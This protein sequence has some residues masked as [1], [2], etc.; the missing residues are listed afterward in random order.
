MQ[1]KNTPASMLLK[2]KN[3][4]SFKNDMRLVI[5]IIFALILFLASC[6]KPPAPDSAIGQALFTSNI[7]NRNFIIQYAS[8]SGVDITSRY[9]LDTVVLT[10]DTSYFNG[11]ITCSKAGTPYTGTWSSNSDYSQLNI[12]ITTP[13]PPAEFSFLN[14]SWRF[15]KKDF[16]IMQLAPW[17][18]TAPKVLYMERL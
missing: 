14:I 13:T 1:Q 11:T 10:N 5:A 6:V 16:P 17:G 18:S 8:D 3:V 7:L 15:T 9:A 4:P 2:L 12:N